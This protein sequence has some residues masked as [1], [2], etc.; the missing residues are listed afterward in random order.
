MKSDKWSIDKLIE[1]AIREDY[2]KVPE[3]TISQDA[4]WERI[5][6]RSRGESNH[7]GRKLFR[8]RKVA[9]VASVILLLFL[10]TELFYP[11]QNQAFGWITKLYMQ[12][13]GSA[14]Q[15]ISKIGGES[16]PESSHLPSDI[17]IQEVKITIEKMSIS[18]ARNVAKFNIIQPRSIPARFELIDVTVLFIGEEESRQVELNYEGKEDKFTIIEKY[19]E[20]QLSSSLVIDNEDTQ[21]KEVSIKGEKGSLLNFKNGLNQLMWNKLNIQ[22]IIEGYISEEEMLRIAESM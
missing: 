14:T 4:M 11:Q 20:G 21:I 15:I 19:I 12:I 17:E 13:E 16:G 3:P 7:K 8:Y 22:L 9:I 5:T 10:L 2:E 18:D 1:H 6:S